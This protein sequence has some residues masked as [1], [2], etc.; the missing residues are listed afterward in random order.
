MHT[1]TVLRAEELAGSGAWSQAPSRSEPLCAE[2]QP[3][4]T[5]ILT[6]RRLAMNFF[7]YEAPK[8]I[9]IRRPNITR[10]TEYR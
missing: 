1:F 6:S 3:I 5:L 7:E 10:H 9:F 8:G 2:Q 4:S